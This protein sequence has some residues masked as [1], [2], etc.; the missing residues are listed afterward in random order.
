KSGVTA[1][2]QPND[3][4]GTTSTTLPGPGNGTAVSV[5]VHAVNAAGDGADATAKATT[6]RAPKVTVTGS[7]ASTTSISVS[8]SADLGGAS[9]STCTLSASGRSQAGSCTG[10]TLG[11]LAPSTPYDFTV[12]VTTPAGSATATGRQATQDVMGQAFC[13]N[14]NGTDP[15]TSTWC[16]SPNNAL[17]VQTSTATL[18]QNVVGKTNHLSMY[19]AFCW[20]T[21]DSVYAYN[22]NHN[23]RTSRWIRIEWNGGRYYTPLAWINFDGNTSSDY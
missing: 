8:F 18:H 20:T 4:A 17:E 5:A 15:A 23:K 14:Y 2:G 9:T 7:S 11:G 1:K 16:D 12:T 22:Y 10:I 13:Q 6:I 3:A 21:G 19:K